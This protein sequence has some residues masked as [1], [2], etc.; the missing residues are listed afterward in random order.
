MASRLL[1][2]KLRVPNRKKNRFA[3]LFRLIKG[4]L[5]PRIPVNRI[6]SMLQQVG[7]FFR[8]QSIGYSLFRCHGT[9]SL[10]TKNIF[11]NNI[12]KSIKF[13]RAI[14]YSVALFWGS[15]FLCCFFYSTVQFRNS[16]ILGTIS[17]LC[18]SYFSI[19]YPA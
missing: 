7:R 6:V 10:L 17:V 15:C 1:T 11:I 9:T 13:K 19:N 14:A 3:F 8:N 5:S 12:S 2:A 18:S 4:F 16:A